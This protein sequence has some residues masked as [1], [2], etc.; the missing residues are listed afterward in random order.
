MRKKFLAVILSLALLTAAVPAGFISASAE[1]DYTVLANSDTEMQVTQ[2]VVDSLGTN[3]LSGC[4]PV[5]DPDTLTWSYKGSALAS[6]AD[7]AE[8]LTDGTIHS[9]YASQYIESAAYSSSALPCIWF[10]MG[11]VY[12]VSDIVVG[13]TINK[14]NDLGLASYEI[15]IS[16]YSANLFDSANLAA[17]YTN[18]PETFKKASAADSEWNG[19]KNNTHSATVVKFNAGCE[20]TGRFFGIKILKGSN[21]P[22]GND[23]IIRLSELGVYGS[24][25]SHVPLNYT[26]VNN[27]KDGRNVSQATFDALGTSI[28]AGKIADTSKTLSEKEQ[29]ELSLLTDGAIFNKSGDPTTYIGIGSAGLAFTYDMGMDYAID[30]LAIC[31]ACMGSKDLSFAQYEIY[32]GESLDTLYSPANKAAEYD[33][34]TLF[35]DAVAAG[36]SGWTNMIGA[37]QYFL[38]TDA[39]QGRYLG[40]KALKSNY[41]DSYLHLSEFAAF[42]EPV[43][44]KET[45]EAPDAP[46]LAIRASEFVTLAATE[47]YEYSMDG[48]NWRTVPTFRRLEI[49]VE[50]SFYQRKA[51]TE[52]AYASASSPALQLQ[53]YEVGDIGHD[54]LVDA[55]DLSGVRKHLLSAGTCADL[56]AADA[57]LDGLVDIRDMVSM[58]KRIAGGGFCSPKY[59]ALT[60][61]D[62]PNGTATSAV[63]DQLEA[64]QAKATFFLIGAHI[65]DVQS[66]VLQR[67]VELGCEFGNHSNGT[68]SMNEMDAAAI[69]ESLGAVD[70][71]VTNT[72]GAQYVPKYFRAPNLAVS[73]TMKAAIT[74]LTWIEGYGLSAASLDEGSASAEEIA[75]AIVSL[76]KDG[77]ILR[78][79]D[80]SYAPNTAAALASAIPQLK[81]MGYRFVTVS[82]LIELSGIT[83]AAGTIYSDIY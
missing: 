50:Y 79:H 11:K 75:E 74:N 3:L 16:D 25:S 61:D 53:L 54:G 36:Q 26:V 70:T 20:K 31:G 15:Y 2:E 9:G 44:Q 18:D 43:A 76:A 13:S 30:K 37:G 14:T 56:Y 67:T 39:V 69:A 68:A 78:M 52:T 4:V 72:V 64:N 35:D 63:L 46:A 33:S 55:D 5:C 51:E 24:L 77:A 80:A 34:G 42:G 27:T 12:D 47:G 73:D 28:L 32:I 59:I 45:Q 60:F 6:I 1:A 66:A 21:G 57:N 17:S 40:I 71:A 49:G 29:Q 19:Q 10:D 8:V 41:F 83:P 48:L 58:K 22:W 65:T 7:A 38:F 82:E 23:K 81:A 62:G